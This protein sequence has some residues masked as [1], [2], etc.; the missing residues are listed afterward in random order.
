MLVFHKIKSFSPLIF[1]DWMK[2]T[3]TILSYIIY[4]AKQMVDCWDITAVLTYTMQHNW[5]GKCS[6]S[7]WF[8]STHSFIFHST[9]ATMSQQLLGIATTVSMQQKLLVEA[10]HTTHT[11][12]AIS[13]RTNIPKHL[14]L[15]FVFS[16]RC[17]QSLMYFTHPNATMSLQPHSLSNLQ[18]CRQI[19]FLVLLDHIWRVS[20]V[21]WPRPW[22]F[23]LLEKK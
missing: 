10:A 2:Q 14:Y 18:N 16:C 7:F 6:F 13:Q 9:H 20:V 19:S 15:I 21:H 8:T 5:T 3:A 22:A 17:F 11:T 12:H 1:L 4:W 23:D